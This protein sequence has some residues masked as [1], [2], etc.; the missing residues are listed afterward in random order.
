MY[1]NFFTIIFKF[2]YKIIFQIMYI[3]YENF[4]SIVYV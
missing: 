4:S 1:L 2:L 3:F